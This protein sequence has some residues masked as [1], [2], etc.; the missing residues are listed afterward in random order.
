MKRID[1]A[2][3]SIGFCLV[4]CVLVLG[5]SQ[6]FSAEALTT[7]HVA[8]KNEINASTVLF[9]DIAVITGEDSS[10]VDMLKGIEIGI[11]PLPGRSRQ[12]SAD[13]ISIRLKQNNVDLS[14]VTMEIPDTIE[15][16][17]GSVMITQE[18]LKEIVEEFI[19]ANMPWDKNR[20][21]ITDV[22]V[23]E[24]VVLPKGSIAYK[25]SPSNHT[26][27]LGSVLVAIEFCV[28]REYRKK[29]WAN[30]DISVLTDV[31]VSAKPLGR[32][33][34]ITEDDL[35]VEQHDLADLPGDAL[36]R[37]DEVVGKRTR[38]TVG[39]KVVMTSDD[40][41]VPPLMNRGDRVTIVAQSGLLRITTVGEVR[42]RGRKG[43]I[44]KVRNIA[45]KK[46]VYA[47][48]IDADT[49]VVEF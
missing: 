48:V 36:L 15:V 28:D 30:A 35:A 38:R 7:I 34:V 44:I 25:V 24:N 11:A 2:T 46:E 27:Y 49:V 5:Y 22:R 19:V 18:K 26:D 14:Q 12:F 20:A 6:S 29:I 16:T 42:E 33:M 1:A 21:R 9:G 23:S 31:V 4:I 32:F 41:E 45:S 10:V 47:R 40:V 43:E 3:G 8:G 17:R 39:S 37:V 13:S